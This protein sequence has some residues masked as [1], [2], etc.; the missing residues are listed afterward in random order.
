MICPTDTVY[1]LVADATNEKAVER[2]FKIKKREKTKSLPIFIKDLKM[3]KQLAKINEKQEEF[4]KRNW[5]GKVTAVLERK[6]KRKIYGV[7]RKT[8]ALRIPNYQ[9]INK[10][11]E[12]TKRPLTGTSANLSGKPSSLK[13]KEILKQFKNQKLQPDLVI[14]A[15]ELPKNKPSTVIDLTVLPFKVLRK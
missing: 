8:I 2:V 10:L 15:G 6:G 3:A 9:F 11:L 13:I 4:L 1:G 14:D 12:K 5:P 7:E